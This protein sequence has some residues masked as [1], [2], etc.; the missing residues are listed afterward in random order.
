[1]IKIC[2]LLKPLKINSISLFVVILVP[3]KKYLQRKGFINHARIHLAQQKE[4]WYIGFFVLYIFYHIKIFLE[5]LFFKRAAYFETGLESRWIL[6]RL[7]VYEAW[8]IS[9]ATNPLEMEAT[10]NERKWTYLR[11][12]KPFSFKKY[13]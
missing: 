3:C 2:R 13:K 5:N 10:F 7:R 11:D 1:M 6:L 12:R 9:Q 4:L 8:Q